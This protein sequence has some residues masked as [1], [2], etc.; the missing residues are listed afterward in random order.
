MRWGYLT[1]DGGSTINRAI[2]LCRWHC[3]TTSIEE[4]NIKGKSVIIDSE[5]TSNLE[6]LELSS[7]SRTLCAMHDDVK[8]TVYS[9][10]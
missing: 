1:K 2:G 3:E 5:I 10:A 7:I 4:S 6:H 8:D 9:R